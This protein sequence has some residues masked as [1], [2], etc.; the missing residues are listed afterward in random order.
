MFV[1][2]RAYQIMDHLKIHK[3]A[4]IAE[5]SKALFASESTIRRDLAEMQEQGLIARYHG[6][7]I[8]LEGIGETSIFFRAEKDQEAKDACAAIA[9][10][11]IPP[12]TGPEPVNTLFID[13]SSTCLAL[14]KRLDFTNKT[15][16]T[17]G[18]QVALQLSQKPDI[19]LIMPG[20][21]VN[22]ST[23]AITGSLATRM[24]DDFGIDLALTSCAAFDGS[25]AFELSLETAL[26][27]QIAAKKSR[28]KLLVA[29]ANKF[30]VSAPYRVLPLEDYDAVITDADDEAIKPLLDKGICVYNK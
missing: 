19:H 2:E 3:K 18:L 29:S 4:T 10:K 20:G 9:Q 26:L 28:K 14:A 27:K 8:L 17:N 22:P 5:L 13:N 25:G 11:H 23:G 16:I 24:L 30:G 15:V 6:G 12:P 7:A 21:S 1:N